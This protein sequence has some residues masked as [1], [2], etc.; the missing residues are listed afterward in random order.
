MS[1]GSLER[2]CRV[3]MLDDCLRMRLWTK[4]EPTV[5]LIDTDGRELA[6]DTKNISE[7]DIFFQVMERGPLVKDVEVGNIVVTS[8]LSSD[9]VRIKHP[10]EAD[11]TFICR[12]GSIL[13]I[14]R[15]QS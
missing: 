8:F 12:R 4:K 11:R 1:R 3:Q 15:K 13:A 7:D 9:M 10:E 14:L 6:K 5:S 2:M